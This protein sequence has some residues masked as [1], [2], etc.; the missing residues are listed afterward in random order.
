MM[1]VWIWQGYPPMMM[2]VWIWQGYSPMMMLVWIWHGYSPMMSWEQWLWRHYCPVVTYVGNFPMIYLTRLL[3]HDD[4]GMNLTRLLSHDEWRWRHH[5][6]VV[7]CVGNPIGDTHLQHFVLQVRVD[8]ASQAAV[9]ESVDDDVSIRLGAGLHKQLGTCVRK[10]RTTCTEFDLD[11]IYSVQGN[12]NIKGFGHCWLGSRTFFV[13]NFLVPIG[14]FY[15]GKFSKER[16]QHSVALPHR[17]ELL[18]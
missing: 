14:M 2:L 4:I 18:P 15:H 1:L 11:D 17:T 12:A 9:A 5:C 8:D 7:T 3:S 16:Q 13:L 6:P 10:Q